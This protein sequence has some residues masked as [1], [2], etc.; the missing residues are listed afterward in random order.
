MYICI[1]VF[2]LVVAVLYINLMVT[3]SQKSQIGTHIHKRE[4]NRNINTKDSHQITK[5]TIE[6]ERNTK[7][8]QK[9]LTKWQ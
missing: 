6:A 5:R 3:T 2:F 1:H 4:R 8:L 9:Q 7:E